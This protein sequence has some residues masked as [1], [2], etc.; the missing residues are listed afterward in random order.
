MRREHYLARL[1]RALSGMTQEKMA[2]AIGVHP[3]LIAQFELGDALP[4]RAHL[5]RMARVAAMTSE[6]AEE[7]LD[8]ADNLRRKKR[9][10]VGPVEG[11]AG[12]E[13]RLGDH[14]ARTRRRL[15]ALQVPDRRPA[16][17][18]P[19]GELYVR[20]C[21]K[22]CAES[23][24]A[25][26][27]EVE[28][29]A[30]L[31][32]VAA[33]VAEKVVPEGLR[34]RVT[35][36]A[37][38]YGSNVQRVLGDLP[39]ADTSLAEAK[40]RWDAGA[41]PDGLLDPGPI[42]DLEGSLRRAQRRFDEALACFDEAVKVGWSPER[43]LIKK[44]FT[45][46]VMGEYERAVETLLQAEPLLDRQAQP[47]L[48]YNQRFNLAV[49]YCHLGLYSKAARLVD[50]VRECATELGDDIFLIRTT[51]LEGRIAAGLGRPQ[52]A[53]R[54]LGEARQRFADRK[55][56]YDVALA[57]LEEAVLLLDEVRTAE[58]K[59]LA[60]ELTVVFESKGVHREALAALQLFQAAAERE[61][62][63][64]ELAR[65]VLGYLF[66]ARHDEGLH[67]MA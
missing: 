42:L 35:G 31:A 52:E 12:L 8:L 51:W 9:E 5:A 48:W 44:G 21:V 2:A 16:V 41:D 15:L 26:S 55:M 50:Q 40:R 53:L 57:L 58:V 56:S 63:T 60:G 61:A 19:G 13:E 22:L 34:I 1:L 14:I 64:A 38:A 30:V 29:A 39:A 3:S 23:E 4:R 67:F 36:V 7:I 66:R 25:A 11:F 6:D 20:M 27:R 45:L 18:R 33:E 59:A 17:A 24:G 28:A 47:R 10:R 62:A 54:L 49:N 65:R 32:R 46:E 37:A 43:A